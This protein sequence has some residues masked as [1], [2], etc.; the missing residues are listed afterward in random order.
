MGEKIGDLVKKCTV[1]G[2]SHLNW[3]KLR[4]PMCNECIKAEGEAA[5]CKAD[6]A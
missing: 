1:C 5:P 6:K 3:R 4:E 2:R